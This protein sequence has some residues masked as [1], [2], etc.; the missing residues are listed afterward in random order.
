MKKLVVLL[1]ATRSAALVAPSRPAPS[2][3]GRARLAPR[4]AASGGGADAGRRAAPFLAGMFGAGACLGPCLDNYHSAFG[5]L[6]YAHPAVAT[7]WLT[8]DA[9]VPP[10]FGLA[11]VLIGGLYVGGDL[12]LGAARAPPAGDRV[13]LAIAFFTFQY[14]FSG[15]LAGPGGYA[16]A[17]SSASVHAPLALFA[18][19]GFAAFDGTRV[20]F[21]VSALTALGG[22]V[23]ELAI[24]GLTD[25]YAYSA[26]D[27]AG[28]GGAIPSWIPSVYF[29][30][31]PA[32]GGLAR[33][34]WSYLG[35]QRD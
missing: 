30:G 3:G 16:I 10:L 14:W 24:T 11:G 8:T 31:G 26:T 20:G 28:L 19:C 13:L 18:L 29:L 27:I 6:R 15:L 22:P 35:D 25:L 4:R 34:W 2:R 5:V 23:I 12:A 1:L 21:A 7:A 9:W 32:V 17:P 33:A